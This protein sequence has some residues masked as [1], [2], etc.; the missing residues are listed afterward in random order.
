LHFLAEGDANTKFFNLQTCHRKRNSRIQSL[1]VQGAEVSDPSLLAQETFDHYNSIL[2]SNFERTQRIDLALIGLP[3]MDLQNLEVLFTEAEV[4]A[5]VADLP[6]EKAPGPDGFTGLFYKLAWDVIKSDIMHAFNAFWAQDSRSLYLLNDAYLILLKKKSQPVQLTDYR[7]ISLIHSF[8]K[9][10]TKCLA[11]RLAA[12]LDRLVSHNQSAFIKGRCIH[13][14]FKT[15]R[16]SCKALHSRQI[17]SILLKIDIAKAFDSMSWTF[18]LEV[19]GHLGFGSRWRNW[20]STIL[21]TA[22]TKV[23]TN[24]ISGRRICHARGLRQ[25]DPLF[26]H[27]VRARYGG[28]QPCFVLA[29][30]DGLANSFGAARSGAACQPLC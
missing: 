30:L 15:V 27:A 5:V 8:S 25:G 26:S 2:G 11:N 7:P 9:L 24:G 4:R 28:L 20:I 13:D 10:V 17:S 16:L 12:V 3:S 6:N 21:S 1:L 22:S 14:N 18:L 19:L 29:G 23:I